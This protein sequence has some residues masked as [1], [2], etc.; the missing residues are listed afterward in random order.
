MRINQV[1]VGVVLSYL[2]MGLH[3]V[4]GLIYTPIM[5]RLLGQSEYGLYNTVSSTIS[6]MGLF[7]LGLGG[8]YIRYF[9]MYQNDDNRE[10]IARLNG[11]FLLIYG[12]IGCVVIFCGGYL[13][14]HLDMVF[15]NGLSAMEY[16]KARILMLLL[17]FNMAVGFPMSVFSSIISAHE[18]FIFQKT[19][20]T[21]QTVISPIITI[22]LLL[23]GYGSV[24]LV[25]VSVGINIF[26]W[27]TQINYCVRRLRIKI[28]FRGLQYNFFKS[29]FSF[30]IY[31]ALNMIVDQINWNIDKILL[32]RFKGT[33]AV[34]VY[35]VGFSL[36]SYYQL[37]STSVSNV[38]APRIHKIVNETRDSISMQRF[39]LT[40]L[41]IKVGR[42]QFEIL[43]L[44]ASGVVFFGKDFIVNIWAGKEYVD[45]YYVA[46]LLMIPA[47][48]ALV[49]NLGIEIQRAQNRHQYRSIIYAGMAVINLVLSIYLCQKYGA[50]GSAIGTAIS[51]IV[52][53]G[54]VM[55][56]FYHFMCNI[57]II[58]FWREIVGV[59]KGMIIPF[60]VG[61][62]LHQ[63]EYKN[64][65]F[66]MGKIVMYSIVY[67]ISMFCIGMNCTE[68]GYFTKLIRSVDKKKRKGGVE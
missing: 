24:G 59:S 42:I 27:L 11:S 67:V 20:S 3:I 25:V 39:H 30:S 8:A 19:L 12:I 38:F 66:F 9:S 48:I 17:T 49:Q 68:R 37:F 15:N 36:Y 5:L 26:S 18:K 33:V 43:G 14:V 46:L 34:A 52:A 10:E 4:I 54:I 45:A 65:Y 55:N 40:E 2:Q 23:L 51:L 29:L 61:I 1:K 6:T 7:S 62:L 58:A 35:S 47:T 31:I 13:T 22:P 50:I 56:V 60:T 63:T 28:Q 41:F 32:G 44:I 21:I 53:N 64:T 57:N 16:G